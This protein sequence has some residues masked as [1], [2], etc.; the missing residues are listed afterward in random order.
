MSGPSSP[1]ETM[2]SMSRDWARTVNPALESFVPTAFD[3]LWPTMPGEVLE[4]VMGRTFNPGG[5]DARTR[6]LLTL[7]ALTML[8][9]QADAQIRM[10][11]RH[12]VAAGA[13]KQEIAESIALTGL[14]CGVPAM[15]RAME[16][17]SSAM[18]SGEEEGE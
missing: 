6:L 9:A 8:G 17:A 14:F 7:C 11:V 5:L 1:F 16:L 4:A 15:S 10:T 13:T 18:G 12:A 2:L 3:S